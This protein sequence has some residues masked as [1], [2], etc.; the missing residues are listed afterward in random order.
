M[1]LQA[2]LAGCI[3]APPAEHASACGVL[4]AAVAAG[5]GWCKWL[6]LFNHPQPRPH[7]TSSLARNCAGRSTKHSP[8]AMGNSQPE[9]TFT[10]ASTAS[11]P[12]PAGGRGGS[13]RAQALLGDAVRKHMQGALRAG[14]A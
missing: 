6:W 9:L 11:T 12:R 1:R 7:L 3:P 10:M 8:A 14:R 2:A 4:A 13:R 5:P